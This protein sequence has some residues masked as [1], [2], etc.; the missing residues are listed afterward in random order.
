M[1]VLMKSLWKRIRG[2]VS[3]PWS[4]YLFIAALA[5]I[6]VSI[7]FMDN[8]E[9][10][11]AKE[12][13]KNLGYGIAGSF[14]VALLIDISTTKSKRKVDS[15][16]AKELLSQYTSAF[17]DMRDSVLEVAE[18]RFGADGERRTFLEWVQY[19][20]C[21]ENHD[22]SSDEYWEN[23]FSFYYSVEKIKNI[24]ELLRTELLLHMDNTAID[25]EY[26]AHIR[27]I[28]SVASLIMRDWEAEKWQHAIR[29]I[30]KTLLPSFLKYNKEFEQYFHTPYSVS[31]WFSE[32]ET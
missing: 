1:N 32:E 12:I 24:S 7:G 29:R 23:T 9:A 18:I 25:R 17:L 6:L 5:I 31:R 20:I 2:L 16:D 30:T 19:A 14:W 21:E 11:D 28:H 3:A 26:R 27:N 15:L 13:C 4:I 22:E 8:D 10:N